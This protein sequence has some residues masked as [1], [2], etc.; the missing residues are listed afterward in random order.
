MVVDGNTTR[1]VTDR[2]LAVVLDVVRG[3][4]VVVGGAA[5]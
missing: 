4:V 3:A 1:A 5:L 2:G